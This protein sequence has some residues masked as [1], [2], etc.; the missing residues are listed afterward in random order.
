[1]KPLI[2]LAKSLISV[3]IKKSHELARKAPLVNAS[4][5]TTLRQNS[6]RADLNGFLDPSIKKTVKYKMFVFEQSI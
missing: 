5:P 4:F 6:N 3:Q 2:W 1:M